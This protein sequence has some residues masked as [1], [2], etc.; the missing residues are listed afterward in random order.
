[1]KLED[2][3]LNLARLGFTPYQI[4]EGLDMEHFTIHI[5]Y[6]QVLMKGYSETECFFQRTP[7]QQESGPVDELFR[8]VRKHSEAERQRRLRLREY[9]RNYWKRKQQ[10]K[11]EEKHEEIQ[12]NE[13]AGA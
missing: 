11:R 10:K 12:S 6:H 7:D 3:I 2:R 13:S 9:Q 5:K 4:E 8:N 1:M